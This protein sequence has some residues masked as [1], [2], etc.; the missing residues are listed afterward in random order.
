LRQM[1]TYAYKI[2]DDQLVGAPGWIDTQ[3]YDFDAKTARSVTRADLEPMFQ[4]FLATRF[5]LKVHRETR[6]MPAFV[7]SVEKAGNKM[8]ANE[9]DF[10]WEIPVTTLPGSIP[11]F[12]G[13][14]CP[15][16]YLSWWL[17]RRENRPVVD[18]T[19]LKGFWDFTLEFVPEGMR[20]PTGEA[21][22]G[23]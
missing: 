19:G 4:N 11:K 22:T 9:S 5:N 6:V 2:V 18:Q 8:K 15:M 7:L 17:G 20:G 21:P 14:R 1:I 3:A 12:K 16:A 10:E 13:N 23:P